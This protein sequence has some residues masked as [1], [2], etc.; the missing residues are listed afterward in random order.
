MLDPKAVEKICKTIEYVLSSPNCPDRNGEVGNVVDGLFEIADAI[1]NVAAKF[2]DYISA[3]IA[4]DGG[5]I[6]GNPN[7]AKPKGRHQNTEGKKT[8]LRKAL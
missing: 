1:N 3:Y 2:D 5:E 7:G 8:R 4:P 6:H